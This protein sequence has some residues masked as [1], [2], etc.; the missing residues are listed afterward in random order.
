MGTCVVSCGIRSHVTVS[1]SSKMF[2]TSSLR[3]A[4]SPVLTHV[5]DCGE[6][7]GP[8]VCFP[9]PPRVPRFLVSHTLSLSLSTPMLLC[10][11]HSFGG[12]AL[13]SSYGQPC[14]TRERPR[15]CLV[16]MISGPPRRGELV[17]GWGASG[18][19]AGK[20]RMMIDRTAFGGGLGIWNVT[21]PKLLQEGERS[22]TG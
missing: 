13:K 18:R 22:M 8:S 7:F 9:P 21:G 6:T 20:E 15:S 12:A 5:N 19:G 11:S 14:L 3:P 16:S 17:D 10:R 4:A 2:V 1:P